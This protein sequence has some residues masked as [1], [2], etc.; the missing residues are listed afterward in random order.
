MSKYSLKILNIQTPLNDLCKY[1]ED[2]IILV[3]NGCL[4]K[5]QQLDALKKTGHFQ[6][7]NRPSYQRS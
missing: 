4:L 7:W 3:Q 1:C 6:P 5:F 2:A